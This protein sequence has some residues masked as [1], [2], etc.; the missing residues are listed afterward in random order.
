MGQG[1]AL[2][3]SDGAVYAPFDGVVRQV[4][5]TR[6]AIGIESEHGVIMLIHIGIGTVNMHGTGFVS[7]VEQGQQIHKGE[8]IMEFWDP[9][10][11]KAGYDDTVMVTITNT[12]EFDQVDVLPKDNQ[13]IDSSTNVMKLIKN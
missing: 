10:I 7:Y 3:P 2:K 1:F 5:P 8:E 13:T 6:H 9:A 12:K 11:K 4:F